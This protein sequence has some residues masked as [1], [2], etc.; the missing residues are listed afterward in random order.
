[1]AGFAKYQALGNDYERHQH[2][3]LSLRL[4]FGRDWVTAVEALNPESGQALEATERI[5]Q[6]YLLDALARHGRDI[7]DGLEPG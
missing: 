5:L 2:E 3:R 4:G 7:T 1:M 6:R